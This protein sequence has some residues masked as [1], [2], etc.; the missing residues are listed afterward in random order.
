VVVEVSVAKRPRKAGDITEL[1]IA[2]P[3]FGLVLN[4]T[5]DIKIADRS[6]F[7]SFE[8]TATRQN[9]KLGVSPGGEGPIICKDEKSQ[10]LRRD[11][12]PHPEWE[13]V[14]AIRMKR[15]PREN[16]KFTSSFEP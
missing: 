12:E 13:A 11:T 3:R 4:E 7:T 9:G 15:T 16:R 5:M 2:T 1:F 8:R 6:F 10:L 14:T